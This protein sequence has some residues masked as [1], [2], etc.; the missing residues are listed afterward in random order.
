MRSK[1]AQRILDET[2][3]EVKDKVRLEGYKRAKKI[4][5][6]KRWL[7]FTKHLLI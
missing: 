3:Q 7:P 6:V 2:P 4:C 1:T 5:W